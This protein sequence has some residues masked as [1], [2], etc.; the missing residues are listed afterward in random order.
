MAA[1]PGRCAS[2]HRK[3]PH[4]LGRRCRQTPAHRTF[5]QRPGCHRHAP[6]SAQPIDE[7]YSC[8]KALQTA[9]LVSGTAS[10]AHHHAR[11]HPSAS[12][13][14]GELCASPDGLFRD[15]SSAMWNA[16]ADARRRVNRLPLGAAALAGTS[17]PIKREIGGRAA[18]LRGGMSELAGCR[19]RPR[20]RHRIHCR[21][22]R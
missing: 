20:L 22:R 16:S 1:R 11:L 8:I 19:I 2:Q 9:L 21:L 14:T 15:V 3:A 4:H 17:Y 6:V 5:A 12:G 18:G 13:A 7:C 10:H